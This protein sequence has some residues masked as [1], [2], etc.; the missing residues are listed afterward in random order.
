M[1]PR[2]PAPPP[3]ADVGRTVRRGAWGMLLVWGLILAGLYWGFEQFEQ[4][5]QV[6]LLPQAGP[7]GE[8]VIPRGRDGHF[9]VPGLINGQPVLF[10][11]DTGASVVTVSESFAQAAGLKGGQAVTFQTANGPLQGR[12]LRNVPVAASHLLVPGTAVAIGL[13]GLERDKALL[14]QSFLSHFNI[15]INQQQ[16][17]LRLR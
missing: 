16:M 6:Q 15:E 10:L 17:V 14:G 4:R 9:R 1:D 3:P 7:T 11:V 12:I 5:Q 13:V 2:P 8:L